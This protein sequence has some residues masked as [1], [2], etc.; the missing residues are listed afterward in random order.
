MTIPRVLVIAGSDSSGGAGIEADSRVLAVHGVY[1][2]T[3]TTALT[4]QNTLG[5]QDVIVTAPENVRRM[6]K[7]NIEDI[8]CDAVKIG[9]LASAETVKVVA[10]TLK[11]LDV[12]TIVL[13]PVMV[14]TSGSQLLPGDAVRNLR[15]LLIPMCTVLTPNIPEA[16]LLLRDAD[17]HYKAPTNLA[18]LER[19]AKQV[20]TLGAKSILLK[21]GHLP[22]TN[23]LEKATVECEKEITADI[24][25]DGA[26]LTTI[27]SPYLPSTS[28]HGTGCSLG[29]A[30]TAHLARSHT[31]PH[32]IRSSIAYINEGIRSAVPLGHGSGPI[33][34][35]HTSYHLPFT[36]GHFLP[37]ILTHPDVTQPWHNFTHHPFTTALALATLPLPTFKTYLIQDY[38]YLTHFARSHALAAYKTTKFP[39]ISAGATIVAAIET[40]MKLHLSYCVD[41]FGMSVDE[42]T[43]ADESQACVA[44]SRFVLDVGASQDWLALQLALLPCLVGYR[45]VADRLANLDGRVEKSRYWRWVENYAADEYKVAVD[46]GVGE[47]MMISLFVVC[48]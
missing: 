10:E 44:Y 48:V 5:V 39:R 1:S 47:S 26:T 46:M 41:E 24:F 4:I 35:F 19:L 16:T 17:I 34:H 45:V 33:N 2:M 12:R 14:S 22:L 20:H 28:T 7:A 31:L 8:G 38:L 29:S 27:Q 11:E 25:Y 36:R 42:I 21:G 3:A 18:D 15:E 40:E 30:I 23:A 37:Y 32:S 6:I 9:M 43:G 13:D